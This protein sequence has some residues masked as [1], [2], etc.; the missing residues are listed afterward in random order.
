MLSLPEP[1][2]GGVR[3]RLPVLQ[4]ALLLVVVHPDGIA[5][6]DLG[7]GVGETGHAGGVELVGLG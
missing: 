1:P 4:F 6:I 2:A 5:G 3:P 7:E